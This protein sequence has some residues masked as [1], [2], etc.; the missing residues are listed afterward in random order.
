MVHWMDQGGRGRERERERKGRKVPW[1]LGTVSR[2]ASME[3]NGW[4]TT[5]QG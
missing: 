2:I 1:S 3:P 5:D 4:V